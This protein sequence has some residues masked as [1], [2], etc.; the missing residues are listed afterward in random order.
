M[1]RCS[2]STLVR[3]VETYRMNQNREFMKHWMT[4]VLNQLRSKKDIRV[5]EIGTGS[6]SVLVPSLL[7]ANEKLNDLHV[8]AV[9]VD[10]QN[11]NDKDSVR[12]EG[13]TIEYF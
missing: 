10:P 7:Y 5:L 6:Q 1:A 9:T 2:L 11:E 8:H 12:V 13:V 3:R 4:M